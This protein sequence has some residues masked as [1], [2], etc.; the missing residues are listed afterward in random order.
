VLALSSVHVS[1]TRLRIAAT[2]PDDGPL[3]AAYYRK[4]RA[5]LEPWEPPRFPEITTETYWQQRLAAYALD[6]ARGQALH[7]LL[8][9]PTQ[10]A[11][12]GAV[13]LGHI[14]RGAFQACYLGFGLDA[15]L[16][17]RGL[18]HE[19]LTAIIA[20]AFERLSIHRIMAN[21]LPDNHRSAALLR[22]LGFVVE[23]F[24]EKYLFIAGD[25]RD[26]VL[27]AL[28]NPAGAAPAPESGQY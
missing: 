4:N 26:H 19:G 23:G 10:S 22:R 17:G 2:R 20:V 3:L 7:L 28:T 9:E 15:E 16:V 12:V 27:T 21:H 18:M 14:S 5:H 11:V 1:T 6:H 8:R 25:W 13:N 24:A